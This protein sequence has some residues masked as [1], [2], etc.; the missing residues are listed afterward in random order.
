MMLPPPPGKHLLLNCVYL[1][2]SL[3]PL[4]PRQRAARFRP[5]LSAAIG[6]KIG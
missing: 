2:E 1:Q 3:P 4:G 6:G 5:Q